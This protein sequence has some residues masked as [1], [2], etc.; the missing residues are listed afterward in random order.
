MR[1]AAVPRKPRRHTLP[2]H[3]MPCAS[4]R[5]CK[6]HLQWLACIDKSVLCRCVDLPVV[7]RQC[8]GSGESNLL[9]D[10]CAGLAQVRFAGATHLATVGASPAS[11]Q[12]LRCHQRLLAGSAAADPRVAAAASPTRRT[13]CRFMPHTQKRWTSWAPTPLLE[14]RPTKRSM[15]SSARRG[16]RRRSSLVSTVAAWQRRYGSLC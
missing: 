16:Q 5:L 3:P 2:A 15:C 7:G 12:E 10:A 13:L 14:T 9:Y 6:V 4:P 11:L 8:Q 1:G